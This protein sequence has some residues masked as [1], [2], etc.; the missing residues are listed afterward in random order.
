MQI[1]L[2]FD[3]QTPPAVYQLEVGVYIPPYGDRFAVF[4]SRGQDMGDRIFLGPI[5]VTDK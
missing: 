5:R 2:A 3:P 4:D 1:D